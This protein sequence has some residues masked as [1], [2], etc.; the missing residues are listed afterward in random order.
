MPVCVGMCRAG[1]EQGKEV[2]GE[3]GKKGGSTVPSETVVSLKRCCMEGYAGL[4]Q[5]PS[6]T[7]CARK[8]GG[9][10]GVGEVGE[11]GR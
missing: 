11:V 7:V 10:G 1:D 6:H 2:R 9:G 5:M 4:V 3:G 8:G